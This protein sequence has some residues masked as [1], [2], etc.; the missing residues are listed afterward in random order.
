MLDH[1]EAVLEDDGW[2]VSVEEVTVVEG[3]EG[4]GVFDLVATRGESEVTIA[5]EGIDGQVSA[6]IRVD[7]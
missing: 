6:A 3:P 1:Y 7:A 4:M 2:D 5:L